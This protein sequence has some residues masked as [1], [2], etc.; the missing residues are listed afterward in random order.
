MK[1]I[2]YGLNSRLWFREFE[3]KFYSKLAPRL[4]PSYK[5]SVSY[6][7]K[8]FSFFIFE[9]NGIHNLCMFDVD[10][11]SGLSEA[12]CLINYDFLDKLPAFVG[13]TKLKLI[14]N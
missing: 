11:G 7:G 13:V 8:S 6:L 2:K 9:E 3:K 5:T 4:K 1:I 12:S 10:D 14:R